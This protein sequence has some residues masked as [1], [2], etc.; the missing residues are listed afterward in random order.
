MGVTE[1]VWRKKP[2]VVVIVDRVLANGDHMTS[3][4]RFTRTGLPFIVAGVVVAMAGVAVAATTCFDFS[5]PAVGTTYTVG[6]VVSTPTADIE[7]TQFQWGNGVWTAAG[8]A[9]VVQSNWAMGTPNNEL[10]LNNINVRVIPD[11]PAFAANYLYADLGGNVNFGVNGD[12]RNVA[13][14]IVLDGTVVGGCDITVTETA[15]FGGVRGEVIITPQHGVDIE[16]FGFGGQ[17]FFV[18]DICFDY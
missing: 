18:D 13:D 17:E 12:F 5:G 2:Y 15:F 10:N 14:L 11:T 1:F 8:I 4:H 9:T 7:L 6:D 3:Q 16:R